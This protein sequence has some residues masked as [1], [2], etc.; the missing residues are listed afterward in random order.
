MYSLYTEEHPCV[1]TVW[2][3][4]LQRVICVPINICSWYWH[5]TITRNTVLLIFFLV[6][7]KH[8]V[9]ATSTTVACLPDNA[10]KSQIKSGKG[11]WLA[12]L[13]RP[14]WWWVPDVGWQEDMA[15]A[16]P[17]PLYA[18][19]QSCSCSPQ[20]SVVSRAWMYEWLSFVTLR[21]SHG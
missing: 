18:D 17:E 14:L 6:Y 3:W 8:P 16:H 2:R 19:A 9:W 10:R 13:T 20:C 4:G 1:V 5:Y 11:N 7:S 15:I 21:S 12:I